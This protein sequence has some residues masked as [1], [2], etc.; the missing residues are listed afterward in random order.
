MVRHTTSAGASIRISRSITR[1]AISIR[2]LPEHVGGYRRPQAPPPGAARR[3]SLTPTLDLQPKVARQQQTC[4]QC[5]Q[6]VQHFPDP[7]RNLGLHIRVSTCN[8]G[9]HIEKEEDMQSDLCTEAAGAPRARSRDGDDRGMKASS[10]AG[11]ALN[12]ATRELEA[13]QWLHASTR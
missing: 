6:L 3:S 10:E 8:Y 12:Q 2:S 7:A 13:S 9:L 5:L 11:T 4:N 1:P